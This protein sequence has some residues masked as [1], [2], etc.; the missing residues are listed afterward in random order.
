M[1]NNDGILNFLIQI[2]PFGLGMEKCE[3]KE[4]KSF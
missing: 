1:E 2:L 3:Y 4:K